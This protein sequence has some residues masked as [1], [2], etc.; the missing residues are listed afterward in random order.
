MIKLPNPNE[1]TSTAHYGEEWQEFKC[2]F[3]DLTVGSVYEQYCTPGHFNGPKIRECHLF[4]FIFSGK[5]IFKINGKT[6]NLSANQGFY[7]D[8]KTPIYYEAD[9]EEPWHYG[10]VSLHG[11]DVTNLMDRLNLSTD[12][13]IYG[14]HTDN[15]IRTHF[16]ELMN[17][18]LSG[19]YF[20]FFS[21]FFNYF[22]VL[23]K[24]SLSA[25]PSDEKLSFREKYIR[26]AEKEILIN[27]HDSGLKIEA[28]AHKIGIDRSYLSRLFVENFGIS[29]QEFLLNTRMK[30]A[31][32]FIKSTNFSIQTVANSV[33]YPNIDAFSK[34]FKKYFGISP[35]GMRKQSQ[36]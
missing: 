20:K 22:S 1:R 23:E 18:Y 16:K 36:Q 24:Y 5:G 28:I 4:H 8:N 10:W 31:E 3:G 34:I 33:G 15:D 29:P 13:P 12:T 32:S 25:L 19:S 30:K 21:A 14:A 26:Q 35:T 2:D 17:Q 11:K 27:Y 7:F 9:S 6:Y